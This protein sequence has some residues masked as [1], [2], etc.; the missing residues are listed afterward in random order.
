MRQL[1]DKSIEVDGKIIRFDINIRQVVKYKD[2][3]VVLVRERKEIPNNVMAYNYLGEEIWKINDIVQT[4]M[5][6]GYD[7]IE[8]VSED[9]LNA[10]YELGIIY[11]IDV[12]K[13]HIVRKTY[14]R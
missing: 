12:N 13:R 6:R 8:K 3:F 1:D 4:K 10:Y 2:F 5:P 14:L 7:E 11:E 9:I